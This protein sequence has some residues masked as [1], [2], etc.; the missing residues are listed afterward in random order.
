MLLYNNVANVLSIDLVPENNIKYIDNF[1]SIMNTKLGDNYNG[2]LLVH[3]DDVVGV[4]QVNKKTRKI[5]YIEVNKKYFGLGFVSALL[6][7][8]ALQLNAVGTEFP[9]RYLSDLM[10]KDTK[11]LFN[12]LFLNEDNDYTT[13]KN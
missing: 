4:V 7:I 3:N 11:L 8:G 12:R 13:K 2:K 1:P 5:N 10:A 6:G 9:Y